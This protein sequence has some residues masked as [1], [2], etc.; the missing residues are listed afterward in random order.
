MTTEPYT[1]TDLDGAGLKVSL[2]S[3]GILHMV[4]SEPDYQAVAVC[5]PAADVRKVTAAMHEKAGLPDRWAALNEWLEACAVE[6]EDGANCA[7]A[8]LAAGRYI[9]SL[10]YRQ[11]LRYMAELEAGQ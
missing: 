1:Y 11:A 9:R 7:D 8:N 5:V 4:A 3:P 10:G 6:F 2:C